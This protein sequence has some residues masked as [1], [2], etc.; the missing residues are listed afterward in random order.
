MN[1]LL[2]FAWLL[3]F[4]GLGE[5]LAR[6][7]TGVPLSGSLWGMVLLY[8]ALSLG[9]LD[10]SKIAAAARPLLRWLGLY[11]VPVGVGVLAFAELL[12]AHALAVAAALL[13]GTLVTL[14]AALG[15]A[16]WR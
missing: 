9:L 11:F 2:G 6:L 1:A 16:R 3:I 8:A 15:A 13:F 7:L 5:G 12:E 14:L 10:E 4:Y